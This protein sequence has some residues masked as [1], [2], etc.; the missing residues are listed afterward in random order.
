MSAFQAALASLDSQRLA[1]IYRRAQPYPHLVLDDLLPDTVALQLE[2]ACRATTTP[3]DSSN[4]FT[5]AR[6]FTLNDWALMPD[7]LVAACG[8]F[9]AGPFVRFLEAVTGLPRLLPDPHVE[10]G[11]LHRT[12]RGGFLKL[13]TDFN[14]NEDLRLY[15]RLNVLYFLNSGYQPSWAGELLLTADPVDQSLT[16]M[17]AIQPRFNRLVVFETNDTT[18]HGHPQPHRFP[19][20]FPRTSLA[21]YYYTASP[22]PSR[23]RRR[24]RTPTTRY[25]LQAS[26]TETI[27]SA[28]LRHRLGYWMR[29]WTPFC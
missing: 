15:R 7:A 24:W 25:V 5:Q 28:S 6:K 8:W 29:R 23:L 13:H 21:F 14:W 4:A 10:G 16:E 12:H 3:T 19:V 18:F 20:D 22:P 26:E 1:Q 17:T 2:Q 11:G 27:Q 9:H